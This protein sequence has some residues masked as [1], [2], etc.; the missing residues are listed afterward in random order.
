MIC[1]DCQQNL[2]DVPVGDP[3]PR[4]G[5]ARRSAVIQAQAALVAVSA[6][7]ATVSIGY[8]LEPGWAYQW[9]N[10]QRHLDRLREQYQGINTLGN[11]DA[12]ETVH[13]LFLSLFH[14][15]DWL[16]QDRATSLSDTIVND[17]INQHRNS[18]GLCR[19]YANTWKHMTRDRSG[20]LIAQITQIESS[21][22]GYK[23]TIGYRPYDQANLPMTEVDGLTL[24]E[25]SEQD[26]REF[27]KAHGISMPA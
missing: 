2:D 15:G 22:N 24:A 10:I 23:V 9:R 8:S 27:L 7:A 12:E 21:P 18:L 14:L 1:P 20:A 16:Y 6:M 17:W 3:C 4:C 11:V 26:W 5:G 13:A 25:E 19:A